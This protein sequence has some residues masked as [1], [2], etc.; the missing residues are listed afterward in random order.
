MSDEVP[1]CPIETV[2]VFVLIEFSFVEEI[3]EQCRI[4]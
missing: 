4:I 2:S 1:N 3:I